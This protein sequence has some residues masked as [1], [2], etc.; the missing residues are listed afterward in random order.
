[1]EGTKQHSFWKLTFL[2]NKHVPIYRF[3]EL[4]S[5]IFGYLSSSR[6][7]QIWIVILDKSPPPLWI[8]IL[9]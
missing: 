2:L 1:M 9:R 6:V 4:T 8:R 5:L 3:N 7:D